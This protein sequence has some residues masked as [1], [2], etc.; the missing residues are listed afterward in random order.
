MEAT[1]GEGGTELLDE[2]MAIDSDNFFMF[3][4]EVGRDWSTAVAAAGAG[5]G[6]GS[7]MLAT[8][9][10]GGGGDKSRRSGGG[11]PLLRGVGG[12]GSAVDIVVVGGG[13]GHDL[14]ADETGGVKREKIKP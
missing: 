6:P 4:R 1:D 13:T 14:R 10:G 3:R 5:R 2:G 12:G 11:G 8:C 7:G 9:S